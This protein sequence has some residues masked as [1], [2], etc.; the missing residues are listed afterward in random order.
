MKCD[1]CQN[2]R[3][4]SGGS[5]NDVSVSADECYDYWYCQLGHWIGE[6]P[7]EGGIEGDPWEHCPDFDR[8]RDQAIDMMTLEKIFDQ[9]DDKAGSNIGVDTI[10][11]GLKILRKYY[12][13][14][15]IDGVGYEILYSASIDKCIDGGLTYD[16]AMRLWSMG[17]ML[18]EDDCFSHH[19]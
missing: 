2:K 13:G 7:E 10:F 9:D 17:W 19:V 6:E 5:L 16:D 1:E 4:H 18:D 8:K 15:L 12:E 14:N 3:Y 11:E